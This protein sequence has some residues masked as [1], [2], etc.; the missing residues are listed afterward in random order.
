MTVTQHK[1]WWIF[2]GCCLMVFL[3]NVDG[4]IVNLALA[5][6]ASSLNVGLTRI[7]WVINAYLLTTTLFFI[8][9]GKLA[10]IFTHKKIFLIGVVFF[11]VASLI[12]GLSPNFTILVLA[13]LLQ[14]I[15]FAFT[16]GLAL[17]LVAEAFPANQKGLAIGL[18]VT[19][20]GLGQA[21]GPTL[22]GIILENLNWHWI[23]L[24]NIPFA[25]ASFVVV[26][27]FVDAKKADKEGYR[28]DYFGVV[29]FG[30][31][32]T[33]LLLTFNTLTQENAR[34]SIFYSGLLLS[35]L[36]LAV[37]VWKEIKTKQPLID[38]TLFR[39]RDYALSLSM[40][41]LYMYAFGTFLFFIPLYL[42][43]ILG[44][45]PL[46]AGLMVLIYSAMIGISSPIAGMWCDNA[47]Y[48]PPI[49][50][51]A[52]ISVLAFFLLA[53]I[54]AHTQIYLV[55][56]AMLCL[57]F[58]FGIFIPST[59]SSTISSVPKESSGE[60][61]G[62]FFTVAFMGM[63]LG[64][65]ISSAVL[66]MVSS[67]YIFL[68]DSIVYG[69]HN[70]VLDIFRRAANGTYSLQKLAVM[71]QHLHINVDAYV[72]LAKTGFLK[73]LSA[74]MGINTVL[75]LLITGLSVCLRKK[76]N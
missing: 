57:G 68:P 39:V 12:A 19:V 13:R 43:N 52:A 66:H 16:L 45:S 62:M 7:Q 67:H 76:A 4:T 51:S 8:I 14:G 36:L 33:V 5:K 72:N 59:V 31:F 20:S 27:L 70:S 25:I 18:S 46:I 63:S 74:V 34:L 69:L 64:V 35:I 22:G 26:S 21:L 55:L 15:G 61:M 42:Q 32:V 41:F 24:I 17:I 6:I 44:Y 56:V 49:I 48:K 54:N 65:A 28:V 71:L 73:G 9:G 30:F 3:A 50:T 58:S 2:L 38:F 53:L 60:G 75:A 10:D 37:F 11:G 40:R 1:K 29:L 23:F 47:G